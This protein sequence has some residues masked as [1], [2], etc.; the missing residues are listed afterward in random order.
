MRV[1]ASPT[2][3]ARTRTHPSDVRPL[4]SVYA[5]QGCWRQPALAA[6]VLRFGFLVFINFIRFLHRSGGGLTVFH[7]RHAF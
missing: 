2:F 4:H 5:E 1:T 7:T 6:P 3:L